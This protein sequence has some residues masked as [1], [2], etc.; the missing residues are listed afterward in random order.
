MNR[1]RFILFTICWILVVVPGICILSF[2]EVTN[3][4]AEQHF[5]KAN[6]LRKVADY[7]AAIA[8]FEKAISLSPNSR[9]AQDA[10]Y[11]IGQSYFEAGQF[12]AAL[13]AFQK[14]VD[15]YPTSTIIPSTELM[16]ERVQEA[17]NTKSLFEAAEKG[18][19]E[20]VKRLIANGANVNVTADAHPVKWTPL[21]AAASEGH[22]QV[23]KVLLEN[24]AE[25]NATD[26]YGF[27]P[28][29]YALWTDGNDSEETVRA[30]IAGG[31]DVNKRSPS[32][33]GYSPLMFA[34]WIHEGR[35]GNVKALLD[36]GADVGVEDNDGLTSLYWAAFSSTR[37]VLDLVL[38]KGDNPNTIHLAA[39]KGDLDRV[40][41]LIG[42]GT[43]VNIKDEFGCTPLHWAALA[44][45]PEV[46]RFLI[47]KGADVNAKDT[48]NF[49]PLMAAYGLPMVELL[50]SKGANIEAQD[51]LQGW[52]KLHMACSRGDKDVVELLIRN[53]ADIHM[54]NDRGATPLWIASRDGHKEI[55]ELLLKKGADI[56]ASDRRRRSTPL[57]IAA[58]SGHTDVVEYLIAKGAD[59]HAAD[60]QGLTPLATTRQQGHTEIVELLRQHGAKETLHGAVASGDIDEVKRLLS[61]GADADAKNEALLLAL[62]N[63]QM[64]IAEQL[65]ADGANVNAI[66]DRTGKPLLLSVGR[67]EQIGFLLSK[68]ADIEAKDGN[69]LTLLYLQ[70]CYSN[71]PDY[72][73]VVKMALDRGANIE[74]RGHS[75][76]T[77][78]NNA[79]ACGRREAAELLL[80]RGADLHATSK[81]GGTAVHGAMMQRRPE[82]VRWAVAKGIAIPPLHLAAYFGEMDRVRSLLSGGADVNQKDVAQYTPLHCA[83]LGDNKEIVQLL[84]DRG[85]DI[86]ARKSGNETPLFCACAWG[87]LE[88]AKL[89]IGEGAEVSARAGHRGEKW[90]NL[91]PL[92]LAALMGHTNIV[93]YLLAQGA[94]IHITCSCFDEEDFTPLHLAAQHGRL[95]VVKVLIAKGADVSLKTNKG[96]T[97][98]DLA[99]EKRHTGVV[100]LLRK[101]G[102]KE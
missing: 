102:A 1:K 41:T 74:S 54:R 31:A 75:D 59:I 76:C 9:I 66:S 52:T 86:E 3:T 10:Q 40:K 17:K 47:D 100:E 82:M 20:Q 80:V 90:Y 93:Q 42:G 44:E 85:A 83:V 21:I 88:I 19:V 25:V 26:S 45:S 91:T 73:D 98:L 29:Y 34:I 11:W 97:A 68:G 72:L 46:A 79:I 15:E 16:I 67:R 14:L 94:D 7:D 50:V 96:H 89:L 43:D 32:D 2:A 38:S 78:L 63:N 53:G 56:N 18:D 81:F 28:L 65:V 30:L 48:R 55:V 95:D 69:G 70:A 24:G 22:A 60:N 27:T 39:C 101:H 92:H 61:K 36:A 99:K 51:N 62:N 23:V 71:R 12:E 5:E 84:I 57:L 8:E 64:D 33:K 87:Y 4:E 6:E 49:T 35:E 77:P 58:R 37:D 13:S